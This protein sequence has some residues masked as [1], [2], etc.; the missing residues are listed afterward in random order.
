MGSDRKAAA[1]S[2]FRPPAVIL[3]I[4]SLLLLMSSV[5]IRVSVRSLG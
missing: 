2:D 1:D 5:S 3:S 4:S